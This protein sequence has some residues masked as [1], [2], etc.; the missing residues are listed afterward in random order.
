MKLTLLIN[1]EKEIF[2]LPDF[3]PARLIRKSTELAE[4]P[5][6]PDK[7]DLDKMVKYVTE[8]YGNQF[9]VDQYWDGVDARKF[10]STTTEVINSLIN[11]TVEA[12]RWYNW[13]DK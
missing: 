9:T 4:I 13:G 11:E 7:A 6:N 5:S 1:G 12:T 2:Q 3:I 10:L 8:V